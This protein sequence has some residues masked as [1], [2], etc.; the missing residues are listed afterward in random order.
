MCSCYV[1]NNHNKELFTSYI[2]IFDYDIVWINFT[3]CVL[4]SDTDSVFEEAA[5]AFLYLSIV[6]L[7]LQN[8]NTSKIRKWDI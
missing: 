5:H 6:A 8:Y 2:Y 7:T 1:L 3:T 4:A